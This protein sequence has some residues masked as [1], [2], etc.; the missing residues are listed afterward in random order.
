[1]RLWIVLF[2]AA[3]LA[4]TPCLAEDIPDL[5]EEKSRINYS[6]GYQIGS[7]FKRQGVEINPEILVR[8]IQDAL[9]GEK[10]LMTKDEQRTTLVNLQRKVQAQQ[11]INNNK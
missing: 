9:S 8:G 3:C 2:L 7:D 1:M 11:K 6:V 5:K 10:A 4:S